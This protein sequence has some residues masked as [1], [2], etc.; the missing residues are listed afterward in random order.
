MKEILANLKLGQETFSRNIGLSKQVY[1]GLTY[2][3][4]TRY[5]G[6]PQPTM[7]SY[8]K[9]GV[10]PYISVAKQIA[11]LY[12]VDID[13]LCNKD[14]GFY[15]VE[16]F[17]M[18]KRFVSRVGGDYTIVKDKINS[19]LEEQLSIS[20]L[21]IYEELNNQLKAEIARLNKEERAVKINRDEGVAENFTRNFNNLHKNLGVSYRK[22]STALDISIGNLTRLKKGGEP[23]LETVIKLSA[24]YGVSIEQMLS[25]NPE[26]DYEYLQQEVGKFNNRFGEI[27]SEDIY[28]YNHKK[29]NLLTKEQAR[30]IVDEL[31]N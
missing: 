26:F 2:E 30:K 15:K 13:T 7:L 1:F 5:T 27:P 18:L 16:Q 28:F 14:I 20:E 25:D 12:C 23:M 22:I 31:L 9:Y 8:D 29:A 6:I 3:D 17:E 19:W 21:S 10:S 4:I 11:E 24:F